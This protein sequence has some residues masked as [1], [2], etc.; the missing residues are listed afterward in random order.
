MVLNETTADQSKGNT[1]NLYFYEGYEMYVAFI[2]LHRRFYSHQYLVLTNSF[3]SGFPFYY[4]KYYEGKHDNAKQRANIQAAAFKARESNR[5]RLARKLPARK[6]PIRKPPM[7]TIH[8]KSELP[9]TYPTWT[10]AECTFANNRHMPLCEM[11]NKTKPA[12][13][14]GVASR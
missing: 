10:C 4:W 6:P 3:S 1:I 2:S 11:C 8:E 9:I 14:G 12:L 13:P 5:S 7:P